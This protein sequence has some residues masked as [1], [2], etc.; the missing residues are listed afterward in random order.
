MNLKSLSN[1]EMVQVSL[2][3]ITPKKP[4]NVALLALATTA[5]LLPVVTEAHKTL[6][7]VEGALGNGPR[8]AELRVLAARGIELDR[9]HD[10]YVRR[11]FGVYAALAEAPSSPEQGELYVSTARAVFPAGL[12]AAQATY[13]DQAGQAFL[14]D[15]RLSDEHRAT[16][17]AVKTPDGTLAEDVARWKKIAKELGDV[18][19]ER[20]RLAASPTESKGTDAVAAR[21]AWINAVSALVNV[22]G[23][24]GIDEETRVLILAPLE[25]EAAKAARRPA[26]PAPGPTPA[27]VP[28]NVAGPMD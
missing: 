11:I 27:P 1:A 28:Q 4:A 12:A 16:L 2:E 23:V 3:W 10:A 15:E 13:K 20:T 25:A 22:L 24:S 8:E 7:A 26:K 5:G 6:Q 14:V 19:T 21:N 18:E 17:K 9:Q